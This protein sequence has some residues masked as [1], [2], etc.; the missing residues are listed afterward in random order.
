MW[1]IYITCSLRAV[2]TNVAQGT[3]SIGFALWNLSLIPL[4]AYY[5]SQH[6]AAQHAPLV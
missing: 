4:L 6:H 3:S 2:G 5:R 1:W